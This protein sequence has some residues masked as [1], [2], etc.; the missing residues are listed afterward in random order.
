[1]SM[2]SRLTIDIRSESADEF[3]EIVECFT[4]AAI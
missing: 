3:G 1:M 2:E 4:E